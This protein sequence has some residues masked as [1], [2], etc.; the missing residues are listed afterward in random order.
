MSLDVRLTSQLGSFRIEADFRAEAGVTALFGHS[1]S[2]KTSILKMIAGLVRPQEGRISAEDL[3]MF[4][5]SN[6][7]DVPA[8]NRRVGMVFQ[9]ARL[10]P[11]MTVARN[12][13]YGR[14]A[15]RRAETVDFSRI[16]NLLGI[17]DLLNRYPATLSGGEKQRV[18]IGRALLADPALLLMD[19]PLASLD[20]DRKREIL[21]YLEEVRDE[22]GLP[23]VYVSHE[24]DEVA[25]LA[26]TLVLLNEGK[27][28]GSGDA[29][30][31]F[32]R[33]DFGPALGRHEASSLLSG[34]VNRVDSSYGLSEITLEGGHQ[35]YIVSDRLRIG[36]RLRM[37]I[38]ARD[39]ALSLRAPEDVSVRNVLPAAVSDFVV[40][41]SPFVEI[42]LDVSGQA[43]RAR[44]TRH[45]FDELSIHQGQNVFAMIKSVAIGQRML[46]GR[47]AARGG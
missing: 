32:S 31:M 41:D 21:P 22:T 33:L 23:I 5:S 29:A 12:L 10:F 20:Q 36:D 13:T 3:V 15:G 14:W 38:K 37:R 26:D 35:L 40:E 2:G 25:R 19:E 45:A 44:V 1:G 30:D 46:S 43:L 27:V 42:V 28:L 11:H 4:D 18:A 9:D 7:T 39:V 16:C 17:A 34:M 6:G 8:Q 47:V 24:V